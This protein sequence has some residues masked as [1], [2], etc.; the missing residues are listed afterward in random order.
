MPGRYGAPVRTPSGLRTRIVLYCLAA[1]AYTV[2][3]VVRL[4]WTGALMMGAVLLATTALVA[5]LLVPRLRTIRRLDAELAATRPGC[6]IVTVQTTTS[7]AAELAALP[8]PRRVG[9]AGPLVYGSTGIELW[10]LGKDK[11]LVKL[12]ELPWSAIVDVHP[13]I[14]RNFRGTTVPGVRLTL[15][16]GSYQDVIPTYPSELGKQAR[17]TKTPVA[18]VLASD[19]SSRRTAVWPRV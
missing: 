1:G 14:V 16:N 13:T 7:Q 15:T 18:T 10:I 2:T 9:M 4:G 5:A 19:L 3:M 8:D 6:G 17:A 11:S 12:L